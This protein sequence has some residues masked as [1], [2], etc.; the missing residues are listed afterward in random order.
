CIVRPCTSWVRVTLHITRKISMLLD[1]LRRF[2]ILLVLGMR[3]DSL[4]R[5]VGIGTIPN[6]ALMIQLHTFGHWTVESLPDD[7]MHYLRPLQ[8]RIVYLTVSVPRLRSLPFPTAGNL[9]DDQVR[10]NLLEKEGLTR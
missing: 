8:L 2:T 5:R 3:R 9:I 1:H 10:S 6:L 4:M 7:L